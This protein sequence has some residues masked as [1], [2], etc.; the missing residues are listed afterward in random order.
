[1]EAIMYVKKF[2]ALA[3]ATL[4]TA[5]FLAPAQASII[6]DGLYDSDYG[7]ATAVVTADPGAPNGN[8]GSPGTTNQIGYSVY[9]AEQG[10]NVYGLL[11]ATSN[12]TGNFW[13]NL[14]F[15]LDPANLN[16]CLLY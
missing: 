13:A 8:F 10:G 15:D 1:M 3:G 12:A 7:A 4:L 16:G 5:A 11:R 9:L 2:F 14:Y 6:V